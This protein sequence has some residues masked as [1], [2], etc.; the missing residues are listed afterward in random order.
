MFWKAL[1][2]FE[3]GPLIF[4]KFNQSKESIKQIQLDFMRLIV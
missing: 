3:H 4:Q 2:D 1:K